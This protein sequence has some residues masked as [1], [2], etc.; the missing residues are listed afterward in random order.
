MDEKNK[1]QML[2]ATSK[3][4]RLRREN[5][6]MDKKNKGMVTLPIEVYTEMVRTISRVDVLCQLIKSGE[7]A[8]ESPVLEIL[9][10]GE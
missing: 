8:V 3:C 6:E 1:W 7:I 5:K 2:C 4:A 10:I 9:E